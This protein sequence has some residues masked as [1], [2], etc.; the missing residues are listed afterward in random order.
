MSDWFL[1]SSWLLMV[2]LVS[3]LK[4]SAYFRA[5]SASMTP[6]KKWFILPQNSHR[7][8]LFVRKESRVSSLELSRSVWCCSWATVWLIVGDCTMLDKL[9]IVLVAWVIV[10]RRRWYGFRSI[11]KA[12][13]KLSKDIWAEVSWE[14]IMG[15]W[16]GIFS[17]LNWALV[18]ARVKMRAMLNLRFMVVC[19]LVLVSVVFSAVVR[20]DC[21]V[22]IE[23]CGL[24][25]EFCGGVFNRR[26]EWCLLFF[27]F[28][29]K[30]QHD[31]L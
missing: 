2:S 12:S 26:C 30:C 23:N 21:V 24:S 9:V 3:P 15:V 4:A 7:T 16:S 11:I 13:L 18:V 1:I 17:N 27:D 5:V 25:S 31:L 28:V 20:I 29:V 19:S 6:V 14:M 10:S 8:N 22:W